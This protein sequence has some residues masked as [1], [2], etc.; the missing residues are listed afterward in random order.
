MK[1]FIFKFLLLFLLIVILLVAIILI[2]APENNYMQ[3][4]LDKHQRL[5]STESPRIVLVGGSNLAFGIDS[6]AMQKVFD[7][8]VVNTGIHAGI[9]LGRMFV[10]IAPLLHPEDILVIAPEYSH[11]ISD[12]N[13][14]A[15]AYELIFDAHRY[16]LIVCP[17]FYEPPS[18]FLP[19][20]KNKVLALIP[21]PPNPLAY[22]RDGFNEYGD[23]IKHLETENQPITPAQSLEGINQ[24]YLSAFFRIADSL[25]EQGIQVLVSYPS[26]EE[27]S[28]QNSVDTIHEIDAALKAKD[29]ITVISSPKNYCFPIEY[30][31]DTTYHLNEKGREIRTTRLI[32]DLKRQR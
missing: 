16:S 18:G 12:W 26:Y 20:A 5:I 32:Q 22:S 23:Y 7:M 9:G 25:A 28:F 31:Y 3:A 21:R 6:K 30:F 19:Y 24:K 8:P 1:R 27:T 13:G 2:P 17:P 29:T 4:I 14:S 15:A 11:F 10:D